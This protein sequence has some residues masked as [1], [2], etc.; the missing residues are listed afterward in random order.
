MT[1]TDHFVGTNIDN[2]LQNLLIIIEI[3]M[4]RVAQGRKEMD[5]AQILCTKVVYERVVIS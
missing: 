3:R 5:R 4:I 1:I 2:N